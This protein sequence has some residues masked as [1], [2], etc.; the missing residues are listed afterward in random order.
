MASRPTPL[1]IALVSPG[2][3]GSALG[4]VLSADGHE[5]LT[6]LTGRSPQS[7]ARA[8]AAGMR[9]A[10][11][12]ALAG[13]DIIL[14]VVPPGDALALV[15]RLRP[16]IAARAEKPLF[17]DANALSPET[18]QA[19]AARLATVDCPLVDGAILGAPP[20][21]SPRGTVLLLSGD[22]AAR[23][24]RLATDACPVKIIEGGIGGASALKM[25]FGGINKGVVGLAAAMLLAAERHGVADALKVEMAEHMPDLFAR[26]QRQIPDML[27]KAYR[28]VAE[29]E[30]IA[31]FLAPGDPAGA[32][33]YRGLAGRF[34]DVAA[35]M[36]G[37]A[38][39]VAMLRHAVDTP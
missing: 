19:L 5:L 33:I 6:S 18:K 34:A 21:S 14:S 13:C 17:V 38:R 32:Q 28:W 3:M 15:E 2:A 35:D 16:H 8:Q 23:A 4:A 26:Y 7:R 11:D 36:A 1:R 10:E 22:E 37:E 12:A 25:C 27:P 29:M 30:E 31:G 24:A 39:E 9:H 20:G